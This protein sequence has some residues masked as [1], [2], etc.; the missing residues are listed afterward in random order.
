MYRQRG[1]LFANPRTHHP[2]PKGTTLKFSVAR[3]TF[4][5]AVTWVARTLPSRPTNPV[6]AGIKIEVGDGTLRLSAFDNKTSARATIDADVEE[7]GTVIV[8]GKLLADIV[9]ALPSAT[10]SVF[11]DGS[12]VIVKSGSAKFQLNSMP[13][14]EYPDLPRMPTRGGQIDATIFAKAIGQVAVAASKDPTVPMLTAVRIV[15]EGSAV[16]V[17]STDRYRLAKGQ[18]SWTP[19]DADATFD[20][21]I[22]SKVLHDAAK[23]VQGSGV[24]SLT[25]SNDGGTIGFAAGG[26]EVTTLSIAGDYPAVERLF[27]AETPITALVNRAELLEAVKRVSLVAEKNAPVSLA[28]NADGTLTL[29]VGDG[30][31][32]AQGSEVIGTTVNGESIKVAFNPGFLSDG[33]A[34]IGTPFVQF[35]FT[36]PVK[37]VLFQG[38]DDESVVISAYQYLLV[39]IRASA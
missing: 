24:V 31:G 2:L 7:Q 11:L 6:L 15:I 27:P 8:S 3:D 13:T 19:D 23:F 1:T 10:V 18:A 30:N 14:T 16:K 20:V 17:L 38:V 5:Q 22:E 4:A 29:T 25:V 32:S 34:A 39:P 37:P 35:G 21:L 26:R 12:R 33:L 9:N 28:F 36:A